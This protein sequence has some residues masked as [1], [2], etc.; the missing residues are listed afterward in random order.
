M[1]ELSDHS[2]RESSTLVI[3]SPNVPFAYLYGSWLLDEV[4]WYYS[5]TTI[6]N[7]FMVYNVVEYS[8][9]ADDFIWLLTAIKIN[10][11]YVFYQESLDPISF[12]PGPNNPIVLNAGDILDVYVAHAVSNPYTYYWSFHMWRSPKLLI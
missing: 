4:G 6:P 2:A 10:D 7:D 5:S 11:E 1:V 12:L 8:L 3:P 9:C